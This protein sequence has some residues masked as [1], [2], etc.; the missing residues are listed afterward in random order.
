VNTEPLPGS[1]ATAD[2]DGSLAAFLKP[3]LTPPDQR[4]M[5]PLVKSERALLLG[6]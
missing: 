4:F 5:K 6:E 1:L 2:R 3:D